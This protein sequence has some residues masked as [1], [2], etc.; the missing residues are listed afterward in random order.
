MESWL[1][2]YNDDNDDDDD[3]DTCI[4]MLHIAVQI[5]DRPVTWQRLIRNIV[6]TVAD[7]RLQ[8]F[9]WLVWSELDNLSSVKEE[10]RTALTDFSLLLTGFRKSWVKNHQA[11]LITTGRWQTLSV[12]LAPI[13]SL[14]TERFFPRWTCDINP[15]DLWHILSAVSVECFI[16]LS[17]FTVQ[18]MSVNV[19]LRLK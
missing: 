2:T 13:G 19:S 15:A 16:S 14:N 3:D 18:N 7:N 6:N 1:S 9:L 12:T 10:Q 17:R 5:H 4:I 8:S 11:L